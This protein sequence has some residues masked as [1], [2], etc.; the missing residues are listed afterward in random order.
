MTAIVNLKFKLLKIT[1]F[2]LI[3][4]KPVAYRDDFNYKSFWYRRF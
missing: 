4:K 2:I 1:D 3:S